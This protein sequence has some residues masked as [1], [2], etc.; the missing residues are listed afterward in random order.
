MEEIRLTLLKIL[1]VRQYFWPENFRINDLT[2]ELVKRGHTVTVLIGVYWAVDLWLETLA[3]IGALRSP[4]Q[5]RWVGQM[6][7][8]I[9]EYYTVALGQSRGFL[10]SIANYCSNTEKFDTFPAG[11]R[12]L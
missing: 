1:I 9:Y 11:Q 6:V 8:C 7:K 10:G 2:Q 3:A 4:R 12:R 5:L